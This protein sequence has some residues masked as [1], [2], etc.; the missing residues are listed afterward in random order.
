MTISVVMPVLAPTPFLRDLTKFSIK[1]LWAHAD[2]PF[3]L[4]I[5]E[6]RGD[7]F[8][9][10]S[11]KYQDK[12][13][14]YLNFN[15]PIGGVREVNAGVRAATG[16]YIV[17]TGNDIVVPP[18]W[19]TELLLP[20]ERRPKDC[21]IST[22]AAKEPGAFIGPPQPVDM[23]VEGMYSPFCMFRKGWEY[24]ESYL[25]IYQDSDLVMRIYEAGLRAY[26]NC[27]AH[28]WHLGGVTNNSVGR[29]TFLKHVGRDEET[30]Y[31]R[32]GKSP[33]AMFGMIRYGQQTY[34]REY[35]AWLAQIHR[36][37]K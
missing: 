1:A 33:L 36:H 35:E 3:E 10:L 14:K 31:Q 34:G 11:G 20:F 27:R 28:V 15:P 30:F 37:S 22:L 12:Q 18:H 32:W 21:G 17:F 25:H 23:I 7:F 16:D 13:I 6:A 26:R 8:E 4:I 29:E 19:D 24:D 2:E 9:Y 5:V